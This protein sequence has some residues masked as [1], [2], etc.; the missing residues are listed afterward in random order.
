MIVDIEIKRTGDPK[1]GKLKSLNISHFDKDGNT[2]Y[3]TLPLDQSTEGYIWEY[4]TSRLD[5]PDG[6]YQSWDGKPVSAVLAVFLRVVYGW[7]RRQAKNAGPRRRTLWL[8]ELRAGA[9]T[10]R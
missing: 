7:Y 4:V 10:D 9:A 3:L 8:G 5:K 6:K 2:T 1:Y